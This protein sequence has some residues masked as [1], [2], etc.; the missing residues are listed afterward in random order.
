MSNSESERRIVSGM[1]PTGK[2]HLG[3]LHGVLKNWIQLQHEYECFFF[4]A[5]FHALT[6]NYEDSRNIEQ[7]SFETVI[8]WLAA[9][10]NPGSCTIFLQS[11]VPEHTELHLLLSMI[12]PLSW[13]ERVPSYK[14]QQAKLNDKELGTYGFLGY[15]LLQAADILI[16]K[17]GK[18]PVGAD[19]VA[20]IELTREIARRFNHIYGREEGFEEQAEA[21]IKLMGKKAAKLYRDLRRSFLEK[22]DSEALLKARALLEGQQNLSIGDKE[23]L[24][25]YLEGGGRIILTEPGPILTDVPKMPGLDGEKMSKSYDN[26][27]SLREEPSEIESK[28]RKMMTDPARVRLKDPGNPSNC[29]VYDLHRVYSSEDTKSWVRNGCTNASIGCIDCK[30]PLID[31]INTEQQIMIERAQQFEEDPDLVHS[32]IQEG[33]EQAR[34]VARDTLD[35]VKECIGI[36]HR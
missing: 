22:G 20:H 34:L 21:A 2:L 24:Y 6:T 7:Y 11:K 33:S 17:A 32:I 27:I 16:Y 25:G 26:V 18:V 31:S 30:K 14:D 13:L 10:V 35:E 1:R 8:D 29:P 23:R 4:V 19:Q 15:P 3:H 9:G 12:T 28:I 36:S 5:D